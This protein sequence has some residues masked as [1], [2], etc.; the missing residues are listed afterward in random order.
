M[1]DDTITDLKQFITA[2]V[3]Q[4]VSTVKDDLSELVEL[5][6]EEN[7]QL[8]TQMEE[9]FAGVGD[10]IEAITQSIEPKIDDHEARITNLESQA[11]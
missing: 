10:A 4:Q 1:N 11:A 5:V 8:K 6:K 9:G 3:S 2:T 7:K